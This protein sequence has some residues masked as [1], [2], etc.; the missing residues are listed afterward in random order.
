MD[1]NEIKRKIEKICWNIDGDN[2]YN[3]DYLHCA[4][5]RGE[6]YNYSESEKKI[7]SLYL[8]NEIEIKD[9]FKKYK[10][11]IP[12]YE[13]LFTLITG[14][15]QISGN[16]KFLTQLNNSDLENL[17]RE[18]FLII[19]EKDGSILKNR[20][21]KYFAYNQMEDDEETII[22][23][24]NLEKL[25]IEIKKEYIEKN[26]K[27]INMMDNKF[28]DKINHLEIKEHLLNRK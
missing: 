8:K 24:L 10:G 15:T 25:G 11:A 4:Y 3:L 22:K 9:L 20:I 26:S 16:P 17:K 18:Y 1:Q 2:L 7:L 6:F 14:I 21:M 27:Q 23:I 5:N 12:G 13:T 19:D 28:I